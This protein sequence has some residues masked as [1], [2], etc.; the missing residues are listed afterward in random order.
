MPTELQNKLARIF[1]VSSGLLLTVTAIAKL[2]SASGSARILQYPDPVLS[3]PYRDVFWIVGVVELGI[4][5]VCFMDKRVRLQAGLVAWLATNFVVYRLGLLWVGYHGWCHCLGNLTDAL[6]IS[7]QTADTAMKIILGYLLV[8]SYA[9]LLWLWS[10]N[11][12]SPLANTPP[13]TLHES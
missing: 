2:V 12:Q 8:G 1:L 13:A 3:I 4:A 9:T 10:K 7:P 6:K 11:Q 5:L